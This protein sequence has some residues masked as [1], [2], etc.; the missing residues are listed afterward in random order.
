[1]KAIPQPHHRACSPAKPLP[2][3]PPQKSQFPIGTDV[4]VKRKGD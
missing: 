2:G 4:P 1:M 3:P